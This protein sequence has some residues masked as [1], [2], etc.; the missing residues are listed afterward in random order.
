MR[1]QKL[2]RVRVNRAVEE[3]VDV[4]AD[5]PLQAEQLAA[6]LPKV[7]SVFAGS[8]LKGDKPVGTYVPAAGIE[9][10]DG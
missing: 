1:R 10:D 3:W 6:N 2:W 9:D 4:S 7:I 5:T 8:A